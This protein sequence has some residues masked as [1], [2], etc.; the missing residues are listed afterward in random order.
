[1]ADNDLVESNDPNS[2]AENQQTGAD[3]GSGG[4][5]GTDNA[6]SGAAGDLPPKIAEWV[7]EGKKFATVEDFVK[8]YHKAQEFIEQLQS[9][10]KSMRDEI[11]KTEKLDEILS[12]VG[13]SG[14]NAQKGEGPS[15]ET[16]PS[17]AGTSEANTSNKSN[18]QMIHEAVQKEITR[19][20]REQTAVQNE[21]QASDRVV[22][23]AGGDRDQAKQ[24]I[25]KA[26]GDLGVSVDYLREQAR[27]SPS[28]F[29]RMVSASQDNTRTGTQP[30][31]ASGSSQNTQAFES[32]TGGFRSGD[33]EVQPWSYW[34][35]KRRE[36]SKAEF[37]SPR[38]QNQIMRSRA[39][40]GESFN[41]TT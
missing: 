24:M 9:E 21:T 15:G 41:D 29:Y 6:L 7:G 28:A 32:K 33:S 1:M 12:R 2:E 8:G 4:P 40:L 26:A 38:V 31:T 30:G 39:E 36:M 13:A 16:P 14:E 5:S 11:Q 25:K 27:V 23:L 22:E 19:R 35:K 20:E 3:T 18:E 34:K 10:N 37:Y 17:G